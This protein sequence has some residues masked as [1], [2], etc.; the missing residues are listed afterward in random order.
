MLYL[1][2]GVADCLADVGGGTEI[3]HLDPIWLSDRVEEHDVLGLEVSMNE[4]QLL[5]F[6]ERRQ[7][8]MRDGSDVLEGQGLE[9]VVLEEVVQVLLQHLEHQ[10]RVVL[11]REAFVSTHEVVLVCIFL[12]KP[13]QDGNLIQNINIHSTHFT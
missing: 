4:A 9:L 12:T 10:A 11:V 2:V 8:L 1:Q 7:D 3:D 13:G 6:E 5:E